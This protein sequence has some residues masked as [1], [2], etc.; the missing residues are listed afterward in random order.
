LKTHGFGKIHPGEDPDLTIRIWNEGFET[1]LIEKAFVYHKRRISWEKFHL[2][3]HKFGLTRPILNKWHPETAK[4]TYWFPALFIIGLVMSVFFYAV[5]LRWL[6]A[7]YLLYFLA[8]CVHSA[9]LNKSLKVGILT[10]PALLIQF[11]GYGSGFL[12]STVLIGVLNRDPEE[13]FPNLFF[14]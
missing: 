13:V 7:M 9:Y 1:R 8:I 11:Y 2:Q 14:K 10:L 6:G 5:G 3:V 12:K 4:I